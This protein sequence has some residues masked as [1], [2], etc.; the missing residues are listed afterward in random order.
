[1][2]VHLKVVEG[3]DVGRTF[4]FETRDRFL[5]GRAPTAHFQ[6]TQD[7]YF[8]R[9]HMM[10]EVNP[11]N[12]MLQDL[13]STNGTVHNTTRRISGH[14]NL[15]HHDTI[16]GGK[17]RIQ[18][19]I[20]DDDESAIMATEL[21]A[22]PTAT[23]TAK[24][25][26]RCLR[27]NAAAPNELPRSRAENM[28]YFCDK[29]QVA[30]VDEPKIAAGYQVVRKLGNGAMGAVY[31]ALQTAVNRPVAIKMIL[32]RA[33]M[34][35]K[36]RDMFLRE[37]KEHARLDHPRV[38]RLFDF[39]ESSPGIFCMV[40]EYV[41]GRDAGEW[42]KDSP[43]GLPPPLAVEIICQ[44][45]EGL[46]HAHDHGIVHRD[47]KDANMLVGR[48]KKGGVFVK[49]SDFGLAKSYETSGAS[50]FTSTGTIA[51]TVPYM[52]PE[53]ILDFRN[54][55]PAADLYSMGATLYHLLTNSLAYDFG[56]EMDPLVMILEKPIV[57]VQK[58]KAA[59]PAALAKVVE[60]SLEKDPKNR[61]RDAD[62]MRQ[63]LRAACP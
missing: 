28:A 7:G 26:V 3:P 10:L 50:G 49:L 27:C 32:P 17:T 5:I 23:G 45:L 44:A 41:D 16:G 52:A 1:M 38:V 6:I 12:V 19:S 42:L 40:M 29:C 43:G 36:I 33:A 25:A 58:R 60:K 56:R 54:V 14:V 37:A 59:V 46:Q 15:K 24:V 39:Q 9:H 11:P 34:S 30:L 57:P 47:I 61:F 31:L 62:E 2:K 8:S 22:A 63:A 55:K 21:P 13:Q 20:E 18:L 48:D 53:Q 35:Q 4:T 51:G